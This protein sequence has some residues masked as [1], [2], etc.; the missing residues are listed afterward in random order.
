MSFDCD[1]KIEYLEK[2]HADMQTPHRKTLAEQEFQQRTLVLWCNTANHCTT[3]LLKKT[4]K[5]LNSI[6]L[7]YWIKIGKK[8]GMKE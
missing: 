5:Y 6:F 2:T 8:N 7:F 1:R 3:V 4:N